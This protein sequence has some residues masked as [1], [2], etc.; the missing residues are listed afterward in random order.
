MD[1]ARHIAKLARMLQENFFAHQLFLPERLASCTVLKAKEVILINTHIGASAYNMVLRARIKD[2][3]VVQMIMSTIAYFKRE[4]M[5]FSWW[6]A[7]DDTPENLPK[8]L[9]LNGMVHKATYY[10]LMLDLH[11]EPSEQVE[12]RVERLQTMTHLQDALQVLYQTYGDA[13]YV[14]AWY[15]Q[16]LDYTSAEDDY[17][18]WYIAYADELPVAVGPLT[19]F[20]HMAGIYQVALARTPRR[21]EIKDAFIQELLRYAYTLGIEHA[22]VVCTA[23]EI[24]YYRGLGFDDLMTFERLS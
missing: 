1:D 5:P 23:E 20:A 11:E 13:A 12:V 14:Q 19:I 15:K 6:I 4:G 3:T 7:P 24:D 16:L 18:R 22:G 21:A 9:S 17:E 10:G 8:L 2:A